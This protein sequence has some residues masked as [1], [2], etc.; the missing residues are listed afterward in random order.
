VLEG[1][2][3]IAAG[4]AERLHAGRETCHLWTNP[5]VAFD[6]DTAA[7]V[8]T[9]QLTVEREAG[10]ERTAC[11]ISGIRDRLRRAVDGTWQ[12]EERAITRRMNW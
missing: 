9:T 10:S 12:I 7:S 6:G 3:A 11:R 5:K 1:P 4:L 2:E 8:D